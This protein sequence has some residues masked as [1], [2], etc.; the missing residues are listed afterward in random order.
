MNVF[1]HAFSH[2]VTFISYVRDHVNPGSQIEGKFAF[3]CVLRL[4]FCEFGQAL[5]TIWF[6]RL[7]LLLIL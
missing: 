7:A 2:F 6:Q 4:F 3:G 1:I 5:A